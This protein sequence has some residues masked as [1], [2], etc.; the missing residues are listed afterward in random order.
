MR[1]RG[2]TLGEIN[3]TLRDGWPAQDAK[4]GVTGRVYVFQYGKE[5]V[6]KIFDEKEVSVYYKIINGKVV[7]LTAK[8]RYGRFPGR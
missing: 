1:E 7:V 6:G 8:A 2:I 5:W 3:I 4:E